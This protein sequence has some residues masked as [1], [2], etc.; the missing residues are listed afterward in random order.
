MVRA[1]VVDNTDGQIAATVGDVPEAALPAGNVT[2]DVEF[3]SLNYKDGLVVTGGGGL[4]KRYPHVP[5]IDFVGVVRE[6]DH[7]SWQS[8]DAVVLT[9]WRVG[10]S[11]WG[12]YAE[13]V[14]VNGDWLVALP[15]GLSPRHAMAIG[16]AGFTAMLALMAMED[17]GLSPAGGD[18]L[19]TGA[20]GGVGS[21]ATALLARNGYRVVASTGRPAAHAYLLDLGA[22]EIIDR[23]AF[24]EP[25]KRALESER[26]AACI[27]SVGGNTLARVLAQTRYGGTIAAVGLAG[28]SKLETTVV[29]FLLRGVSLLGIDSV[30]CPVARRLAAWK[31]LVTE[32]PHELIESMIVD[33]RL[34]DV[35]RLAAEI[36]AGGVRGRV[37]VDVRG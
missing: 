13:R 6:S 18:V 19:V 9:G 37:V 21:V 8:G 16:T 15:E 1:L 25:S 32:L 14:R 24:A 33:A 28:G 4:V 2:V 29:P 3:S 36:L 12:G 31:R 35:P 17:L 10:E 27:D 22:A 7:P 26:W 5:G 11:Q 20:A 34:A 23:S 30:L